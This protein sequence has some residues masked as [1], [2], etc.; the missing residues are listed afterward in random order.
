MRV[1]Y[2]WIKEYI[3]IET[4]PEEIAELLTHL[5]LDVTGI[6]YPDIEMEGVVVG[7]I[8]E[9]NAGS[10][11][12]AL[13]VVTDGKKEFKVI[14]GAPNLKPRIKV[15]FAPPGARIDKRRSI[16]VKKFEGIESEGM[17]CSEKEL[18][19]GEDASGLMV[20][21]SWLE[22]GKDLRS[23]LHLDDPI[24]EIEL[25]ANRPDCLSIIGVARELAAHYRVPL[26]TP[27]FKLTEKGEDTGRFI[28]VTVTDRD[29]CRRYT[30]RIIQG[31]TCLLYTSPSPRDLSTSRMPSSA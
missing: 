22:K 1:P 4:G 30:G 25:T 9:V 11:S 10:A 17:L 24:L 16:E 21:P 28:K 19:L 6:T 12:T 29:G 23:A 8:R 2:S 20:L 14:C 5:G 26:L 27:R 3:P 13:A 31:V 7:E 18:K 15:P